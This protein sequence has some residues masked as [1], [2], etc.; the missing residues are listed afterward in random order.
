MEKLE[1]NVVGMTCDSCS[2]HVE[3]ALAAAGATEVSADWRSGRATFAAEEADGGR[4][5]E[6]VR[7]AG[8]RPGSIRSVEDV[9]TRTSRAAP[10]AGDYDLLAIGAGGASFGAA[11]RATNLSARVAIVENGTIGGTCVNTGCVPSKN[12]LAAAQ[13][14]HT[15]GHHPFSGVATSQGRVDLGGAVA[16]KDDV[17]AYLRGWKYEELAAKYGFELIRGH[18]RFTGPDAVAVEGREIRA[19]HYLVATGATP[20][21]P[22]IPGLEESGYLTSTTALDLKNLP[23]SLVVI[24]GN[25]IGLEMGQLFSRLGSRV[26][27]VEVLDRLAPL[28]EPELSSWITRVFEDEGIEVATSAKITRVERDGESRVVRLGDGRRLAA[29]EILV[30]TGRRPNVEGFGLEVAGIELTERGAIKVDEELRT[31]NRRVFAAGDVTGAPQFVYV[32]AAHGTLAAENAITG[33]HRKMDY[34][35]LPRVT[36]TEPQIAAVGLTDEEANRQGYRCECRVVEL[37]HIPR[38]LVNRDTRGA[39]K[40]VAEQGTGRILGVHAV[41]P[42]AGDVMIGAVYAIKFGLTVKDLAE[43]WAPYL[44]MAEGLKLTAQSF[45]ADVDL[46]SCCAA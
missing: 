7:G 40:I 26:T 17:V 39:F 43:T 44:T 18:A 19:A 25:Y 8:Y 35:A 28:E 9:A 3:G 22:P 36:F 12:L 33:S 46:L 32:A 23:E 29:Q 14:Y 1:M 6:A 10:E 2:R 4:L 34:A 15:A 37:E 5:A 38:P 21:A 24:G 31:T 42:N 16:M 11:I 13:A 30:A 27:V 45:T 20:W 41:A